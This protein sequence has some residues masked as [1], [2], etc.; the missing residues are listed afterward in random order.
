MVFLATGFALLGLP[1][2]GRAEW[3]SP[4]QRGRGRGCWRGGVVGGGGGGCGGLRLVVV[5]R[6]A[7]KKIILVNNLCLLLLVLVGAGVAGAVV[8]VV[9]VAPRRGLVARRAPR[10][11]YRPCVSVRRVPCAAGGGREPSLVVLL[12]LVVFLASGFA[13][14]GLPAAILRPRPAP[15]GAKSPRGMC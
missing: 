11:P 1:A 9:V 12:V 14:L 15:A 13:L 6:F 10:P 4:F 3:A 7:E 8:V 2:R 5:S